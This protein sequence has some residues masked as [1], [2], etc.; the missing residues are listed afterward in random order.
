MPTG[1]KLRRS[2]KREARNNVVTEIMHYDEI[3]GA[4]REVATLRTYISLGANT[5]IA[6]LIKSKGS[7]G[8]TRKAET[9]IKKEDTQRPPVIK[10]ELPRNLFIYPQHKKIDSQI[11]ADVQALKVLIESL[12][13]NV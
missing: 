13:H 4:G 8:P 9:P 3:R 1:S 7:A 2:R 10:Q 11:P 5:Y 6:S 12:L